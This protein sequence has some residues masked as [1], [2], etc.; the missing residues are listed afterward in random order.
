MGDLQILQ[1][2]S[3]SRHPVLLPPED[4]K[5]FIIDSKP[6][7][8]LETSFVVRNNRERHCMHDSC[9]QIRVTFDLT[10]ENPNSS[11][12][13]AEHLTICEWLMRSFFEAFHHICKNFQKRFVLSDFLPI[14]RDYFLLS[15]RQ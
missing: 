11:P 5:F 12:I 15:H 3:H 13:I 9:G 8:P 14:W 7:F 10:V 2:Q 1:R 4:Q 6:A